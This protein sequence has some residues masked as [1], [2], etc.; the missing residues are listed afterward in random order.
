MD[1]RVHWTSVSF[2]M[3]EREN[4][5]RRSA[6]SL[7]SKLIAWVVTV[8]VASAGLPAYQLSAQVIDPVADIPSLAGVKPILPNVSAYIKDPIAAQ[9][10]GKALFWDTQVGSDGQA[11]ATCHFHAGADI[12][13]KNQV[14]PSVRNTVV[15]LQAIF[16][17][18]D[19]NAGISGPNKQYNAP[20]FPFHKLANV[21]DRESPV[22]FD[23][24]DVFSSQGT[25]AGDFISGE[26]TA[27][28]DLLTAFLVKRSLP[29]GR[30]RTTEK[31][32]LTYSPF[33]P[34]TNPTGNPFHANGLIYR[35]V[36]PRQTPT[37]VNAVYNFRQFWDGRAN[38][39]FNGV[40]PFG[41]RTFAPLDPVTLVGNPNA[42]GAGI[43]VQSGKTLALT[44]PLIDNAS[45]ASQAVGPPLSDFEM[46]CAGKTFADLGA[47][48][49][50]IRPLS[51]QV[52]HPQDSLFS[53]TPSLIPSSSQTGLKTTYKALVEKAFYPQYW[54]VSGKF[55]VDSATGSI[56]VDFV[57]G[58]TQEE[59]NFSLFWGLAIQAYEQLLISDDAP[60]DHGP[61]AMSQQAVAG[62]AIFEGKG[63]C[64]ACHN[65][66]L[67]SGATVTSLSTESPKSIEGMLMGDGRPGI[68]DSGFY[69]IGARPTSED[70]GVG[71][72][73]PYGFD[74]SF[75][76]QFK[77]RLLN[78]KN[79]SL[80]RF[81][82]RP[83]E[84]ET[85]IFTPC[86]NLP[87]LTD[88]T[89]APRDA[90][91]GSFKVPILRN[92]GLNPPYFHNG[93]Q[94]TLKDV[95]RFYNRGGDRRGPLDADTT[96]LATP[97]PFGVINNTNLDPDIGDAS[98]TSTNN[99]LGLTDEEEEDLVQFLLSL[100]DNRVACHSGVFDH[101]SLP[102][103]SGQMDAA[104][105][106]TQQAKD[107]VVTLP[108]V[109][110]QGLKVCFPN[111]GDLFGTLNASDPRRLQDVFT[112]VVK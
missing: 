65:G 72:T 48:L 81:E 44:K 6:V 102:I 79:K 54:T 27:R 75:T 87:S 112:Q 56:K 88:P 9:Q 46:S 36:E 52:V 35:K 14:D 109:G 37:T 110:Q 111:S 57:K 71:A 59:L 108:A 83:C 47:K 80:D 21:N 7:G 96:G 91:D 61:A 69:N 29:R 25:Y 66:P 73:D 94:A 74:L 62:M 95:V 86:D 98:A 24:N 17:A 90:V 76:R 97:T 5:K 40:D 107:V 18:R 28:Q 34:T 103:A 33:N 43:L 15:A 50:P 45:L 1:S 10:L 64:V 22:T 93:G 23:T 39:Q 53:K 58:H 77:W 68:Y 101:P 41:P 8:S 42:A 30:I 2:G 85:P 78:Q 31:C 99:S 105:A 100:T 20:D 3:R 51:T 63:K 26:R 104:K 82:V 106:K 70:L 89:T 11:C 60:F 16:D 92:V 13:I 84:F 49:L 55:T 12:R 4:R 38:S 32:N 19:N 67:L